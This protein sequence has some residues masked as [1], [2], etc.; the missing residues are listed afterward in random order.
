ME[1]VANF[2][3]NND[4]I[5]AEFD[6][7]EVQN[8]DALFEIYAS[9]TTWGNITG[10]IENQTD[11]QNELNTLSG[12]IDSNHQ[13]ITNISNT[14]QGYGDIVTHDAADFATS[15]QG[16]KA[17]TALQPGD[18]ITELNNNAGF[19]TSAA[20]GDGTLTIQVNDT[21]IATF[22]ANQSGNTT[23]NILVPDSATWGNITGTLSNQTDL[24]DALNAKQDNLTQTQLDAVNSGANTTNI[25]QIT[26]NTN[27]ISAINEK[28]P[29]QATTLN[30][31]AD[32]AFV[33]SS[34]QTATAN[35]RGNWADWATVPTV[36]TDYPADYAG[37]KTPTVN[38]YLVVQD[39]SDYTLD[40]LDGTWRFKYSGTWSTDGKA[41]WLP[42]YQVNETPL[43]AAQLAA[44]NSGVTSSDVTLIGTA[45]QPG[46]NISGLV[47]D[48]KYIVNK[49]NGTGSISI[50]GGATNGTNAV[51]IG[52][53]SYTAGYAVSIGNSASAN[54]GYSV[55]IGNSSQSYG[56]S[57]VAIGRGAYVDG[58]CTNAVALGKDAKAKAAYSIQIGAGN[59][60]TASSMSVG[61]T[62]DGNGNAVNYQML[63]G[64]TGLIPDARLSSN[65]ARTSNIPTV[66]DATLTIQKNGTDVQTFTANAS[67]NVTANITVPTTANDIN[68]ADN[69]LSNVSSIDAG[70][71]VQTALDDKQNTLTAGTDLEIVSGGSLIPLPTGYTQVEYITTDGTAYINTGITVA[72][73]DTLDISFNDTSSATTVMFITGRNG[74]DGQTMYFISPS[75]SLIQWKGRPAGV[76]FAKNLDYNLVLKSGEVTYTNAYGTTTKTF[77]GGSVADTGACLIGAGWNNNNTTDSRKFIGNISKWQIKDSS[78]NLRFNGVP[79]YNSSDV[80]GLYDTVSN[81]F[82]PSIGTNDF[83]GG[84]E[85]VPGTV[86]N[87]TG[88]IPTKTSDITNDSGYIANTATGT[89]ALTINGTATAKTQAIN[90]GTLSQATANYGTTVGAYSYANGSKSSAFGNYARATADRAIQIGQGN[91]S[92]A[93][94]L[95]IGFNGTS[96]QL[97]DG[98][99]GLI[100]DARLSSNI[101][102]TTNIPTVGDGTITFTQGGVTKGTITTNQSGNTTI[103]FDSGS[104]IT[105]DQT[106]DGTSANAQSGVAIAGA[107]FL[108]GITSSDVTTA[109]GYTPVN[110]S[111]LAT[112]AT[113]GSYND[114]SNKPTIPAAQVNS[115]WNA[116][117]GV[118]EILN[119]PTIPT[120]TSQ[121]TNDSGFIDTNALSNGITN[122]IF[123]D[124]TLIEGV[125]YPNNHSWHSVAYGNSKYVALSTEGY[126]T[127]S[128]DGITWSTATNPAGLSTYTNNWYDI[129]YGDGKF[130]ALRRNGN[131]STST[132]GVTWTTPTAAIGGT[133]A[134][135]SVAYGNNKYIT[136][137]NNHS[138]YAT[139]SDGE[140]WTW[141]S[142][143][144]G[145]LK[146]TIVSILFYNGTFY[147]LSEE[148]FI[149]TSTDGITWTVGAAL[150]PGADVDKSIGC[151]CLTHDG[152]QFILLTS[153]GWIYT[154]TDLTNWECLSPLVRKSN[155]YWYRVV[156]ANNKV[157]ALSSWRTAILDYK[158]IGTS[159]PYVKNSYYVGTTFIREWSDGTLEQWCYRYT[160]SSAGAYTITYPVEFLSEPLLITTYTLAASA[161]TSTT[162]RNYGYSTSKTGFTVYL[163]ANARLAWYARGYEKLT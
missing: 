95:Q 103:D 109:L 102:R 110:P 11:L 7:S 45:L 44:L 60:T 108:T 39:A 148:G 99:T 84:N 97:L 154:S 27:N 63:D 94:T 12:A 114:L 38:D 10:N 105:V 134:Y 34:V 47:N 35:F 8:F 152:T 149:S 142:I 36:A 18:N 122:L 37:S 41:G 78:N 75:S 86:I 113:S 90:I 100:P 118:A 3:L 133:T 140:T 65:I 61:F 67:S 83:T 96:Y 21:D 20:I 153:Q 91:N 33:N 101:A 74:S 146:G 119:K 25:G 117:S 58:S 59:N 138:Y 157:L 17:D 62:D 79:C 40:T 57:G 81:T 135:V 70:S 150:L 30:Q 163:A 13:E 129:T 80:Y 137:D 52:N 127:T 14:M 23:A 82:F 162:T 147:A 48:S 161:T 116:V 136:I 126:I 131:I 72:E 107:G 156:Y 29:S 121:L 28:I 89:S 54:G 71:A 69:T 92:T 9:G 68:A 53:S 31:L 50:V 112:V 55:C 132:D 4:S 141:N 43:T 123:T 46:D 120:A 15:A 51:N 115:D 158:H 16:A 76:T 128:T 124:Y 64:A 77:T 1:F 104:S 56:T 73:T 106:Y 159:S 125:S 42:E 111:N 144:P 22:T 2:L 5:D 6:V 145:Y 160:Q 143:T 87:F 66:N 139:S 24:Q 85:V 151:R 130:V 19:I 26:T 32:K 98:T 88:T 93:D 49:A 155:E